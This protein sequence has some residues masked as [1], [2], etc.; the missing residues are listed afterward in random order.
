[1]FWGKENDIFP[2]NCRN[3]FPDILV[4]QPVFLYLFTKVFP[5]F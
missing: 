2:E 1:M 4:D 5:V 3:L